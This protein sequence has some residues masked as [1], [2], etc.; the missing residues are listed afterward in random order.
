M[1]VCGLAI[2]PVRRQDRVAGG[3]CQPQAPKVGSRTSAQFA[4][5]LFSLNRTAMSMNPKAILGIQNLLYCFLQPLIL[6]IRRY[7]IVLLILH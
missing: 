5:A 6:E 3:C 2:I 7:C 4:F 1:R